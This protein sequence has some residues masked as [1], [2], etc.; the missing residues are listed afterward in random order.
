MAF[1]PRAALGAAVTFIGLSLSALPAAAANIVFIGNSFTHGN[2]QPVLRYNNANVID[3]NGTNYGGVPGIFKTF[4]DESGL[5]YTVYIEA[6]SGQSLQYHYNNKRTQL[7]SQ[8][9]D[10]VVMHDYSTLN[11]SSPGNPANLYTYSALLEQFVHGTAPVANANA[12][13]AANVYLMQTWARADQVY[14]TPSSP[15][16]NTSLEQMTSDL[17]NAYYTAAALDTNIKGVIPVGDAWLLSVNT[18][19]SDRNPYNGIEPGKLNLWNVDSYHASIWGSYLE[20]LTLYGQITGR[21]PRSLGS[22]ESAAATLGISPIEATTLQVLA[23][24]QLQIAAAV[25]EPGT[26]AL[27]L[28]GL[29]SVVLV[30]RRRAKEPALH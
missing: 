21:D 13:P 6:V 15:W 3:L 11:S 25:P 10:T 28:A 14:N 4:A 20:A 8:V 5:A 12:N 26:L 17:H 18:G 1:K 2:Y 19:I 29:G 16:Y 27:W 30:A 7:A 24:Q 22:A 9:W 23:F